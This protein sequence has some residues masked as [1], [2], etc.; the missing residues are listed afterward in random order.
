MKLSQIKEKARNVAATVSVTVLSA[1]AV[2]AQGFTQAANNFTQLFQAVG[3]AIIA[4]GVVGGLG[5]MGAGLFHMIKKGGDRGEDITWMSIG[6]KI[7]GG[8][9][10][11][12]L[13]WLAG[14][15]VEQMGGSRGNIGAGV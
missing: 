5:S 3:V 15:A 13:G 6:Y 2:H 9:L 14:T 12:V 8:A 10:L 4:G 7:F 1:P 11:M